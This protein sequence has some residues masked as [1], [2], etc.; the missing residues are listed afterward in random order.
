[1]EDAGHT[2]LSPH[3]SPSLKSSDFDVVLLSET[4]IYKNK[5]P[6]IP[7]YSFIGRSRERVN[8]KGG[9]AI[10]IKKEL[11]PYAVK[12]FEGK[13]SNECLLVKLT[14][15]SPAVVVG[16][17]YGNQ[18]NTTPSSTIDSNLAEMF[19]QINALRDE[20]CNILV[21]GDINVHVGDRVKGN[22]PAISKG[23]KMLLDITKKTYLQIMNAS[24]IC[25]G[26]WT[27]ITDT[28]KSVLDYI[29]IDKLLTPLSTKSKK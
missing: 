13:G 7:R 8:T 5:S 11:E 22:D 4:H 26:T 1:M 20:G 14:C 24:L 9:V 25:E 29:L 2:L 27:R 17:Y 15:Y 3:I 16:I 19:T 28:C 18:E 10:G 23:G 21:G 12:V 6:R